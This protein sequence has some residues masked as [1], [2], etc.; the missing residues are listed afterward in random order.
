MGKRNYGRMGS[1]LVEVISEMEMDE[2]DRYQPWRM[3]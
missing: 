1:G 2:S 3:V